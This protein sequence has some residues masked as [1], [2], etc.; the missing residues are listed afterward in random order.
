M[1]GSFFRS[2][3][4]SKNARRLLAGN[5]LGRRLATRFVAGEDLAEVINTARVTAGR[6]MQTALAFLGEHVTDPAEARAATQVYIDAASAIAREQL[7]VYLSPK[8]TQLGLDI[9][10]ES[11]RDNL[12]DIVRAAS[13]AGIFVCLDM[14][15]SEYTAV[16][17]DIAVDFRREFG[18]VGTV[19]QAYLHR[20]PEDLERL[21]SEEVTVRLVKGAYNEPES[22]A[23]QTQSEVE[24]AYKRLTERL[25]T[26]GVPC[27]IATHND[28]LLRH[29]LTVARVREIPLG[30]FEVQML[31]GIRRH[32]QE[33]L[34]KEGYNVRVYLPFGPE[35]F[36]YF[37]RRLGERPAN[38]LFLLRNLFRG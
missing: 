34:A 29:T 18:N 21:L 28:D 25:L 3:G 26:S 27:A 14:E 4:D 31:F 11:C 7:P 19:L 33:R 35:W 1:L 2:L 5:P 22:I 16:T 32:E 10:E 24:D 6:G 9:S 20:A 23:Y 8:L 15:G 38:L 13:E 30:A 17:L 37:M 12:G 36:P